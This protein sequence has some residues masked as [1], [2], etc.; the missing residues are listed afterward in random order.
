MT[1]RYALKRKTRKIE[2]W[3][4]IERVASSNDMTGLV[5]A[6]IENIDEAEAYRELYDIPRQ[7]V[8]E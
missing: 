1:K 6:H 7:Q 3:H 5:P 8:D 2:M 4:D